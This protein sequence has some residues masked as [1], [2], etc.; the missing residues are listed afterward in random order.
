MALFKLQSAV[1]RSELRWFA[2]L[3]FPA[4]WGM[5]G[6]LAFRKLDAPTVAVWIWTVGIVISLVGLASPA[7]MRPIY[8][9]IMLV[10][11]PIGWVMS[12]VVLFIVY[13]VVI[14]GAGFLVR[15]FYD[16]MMRR[17]DPQATSYWFPHEASS[18]ERYFRQF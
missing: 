13:F 10:T 7:V 5:V 15:R 2:G 12:H 14:T 6:L 8:R 11:F 9:M 1:S 3:W 16:P 18:P 17:F 4:F